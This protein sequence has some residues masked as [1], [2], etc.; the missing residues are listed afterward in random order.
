MTAELTAEGNGKARSACVS[1]RRATIWAGENAVGRY[2]GT[3]ASRGDR[4]TQ[5]TEYV[6]TA[7]RVAPKMIVSRFITPTPVLSGALAGPRG[8]QIE[9]DDRGLLVP[10][11]QGVSVC[12][13][14]AD[15]VS[16]FFLTNALLLS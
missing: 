5:T 9:H 6:H 12:V 4:V 8:Q 2:L 15:V 14:L 7:P 3:G 1:H 13:P 16:C 11:V 10:M